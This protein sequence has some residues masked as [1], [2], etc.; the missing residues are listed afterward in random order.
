MILALAG[1]LRA[2]DCKADLLIELSDAART[3]A[4]GERHVLE[5]ELRGCNGRERLADTLTWQTRDSTIVAVD[6]ARGVVTG[7]TP[8]RATVTVTGARYGELGEVLITVVAPRSSD[9]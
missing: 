9:R 3:L 2:G 1:C 5:V 7:L 6:A 8:G 4:V